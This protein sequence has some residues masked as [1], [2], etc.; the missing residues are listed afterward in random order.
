MPQLT[1][2][3]TSDHQVQPDGS[4]RFGCSNDQHEWPWLNLPAQHPLVIQTQNF[5]TSVGATDA[6][7]TRDES[8]WSALT[9]TDWHLGE[10]QSGQAVSG[11][12]VPS[13]DEDEIAFSTTLFDAQDRLIVTMNGKGVIFRN[14]NFETWREGS[15]KQ[16]R[17]QTTPPAGFAY[18]T[19]AMLDLPPQEPPLLAPLGID[20]SGRLSTAALITKENGLIPGHPYFSGSGDHVNTP[21]LA[22]IGRQVVS[23]LNQGRSPVINFGEMDMHRYIELGTAIDIV[24]DQHSECAANLAIHQLGKSCAT[25]TMRWAAG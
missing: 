9:W 11:H 20:D 14:R 2:A 4:V 17:K 21:H 12:F 1:R 25:I 19:R 16:A 23:L 24:I 6:L 18:A 8:K 5:W 22:E 13:G 3:Y 7:G 15:K 10:P